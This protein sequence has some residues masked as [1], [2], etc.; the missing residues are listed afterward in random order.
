M[1]RRALIA[2]LTSS[3]VAVVA[4]CSSAA[5]PPSPPPTV[6]PPPVTTPPPLPLVA[7]TAVRLPRPFAIDRAALDLAID[8]AQTTMTGQVRLTGTMA[9]TESVIWLH[10]EDLT[11]TRAVARFA[12]PGPADVAKRAP[13]PIALEVITGLARG[14]IALRAPAPL[15]AGAPYTLELDYQAPID[16]LETAGTFRQQLDGRWYVFS[17]HEAIAARRSFPCIDEPDL[18]IPWTVTLTVPRGLTAVA[19]APE[20]SSTTITDGRQRFGFAPTEAIPS[21]LVAYAVGPFEIVPAG[22]TSGGAPIRIIVPAGK[23]AEAA[24]AAEA[25]PKL[26]AALER[27]FGIPYPFAKLDSLAI[28]TTVGFGAMENPGLITY[29]E[30]LLL[31]PADAPEAR[32]RRYVGVGTHEMAHQW[33]GDLVTP[34]WWDDIW[35]NESFATWMPA[36]VIGAVY[37]AF[38]R[39]EDDALGRGGA[40]G[41]DSL[42]TARR[43]R[44]PIVA[45]D[46]I[47]NAFDGI[48][49]GKGA[50]V[51]RMMEA[52]V[53]ADAFQQGIRAYL[54][55]H[56]RGNAT[57]ADFVAAI[58]A[59]STA[60]DLAAAF[61]SFLDQAGAPQLD[62][63]IDCAAGARP[64]IHLAQR[65]YQT[66][67]A[68]GPPGVVDATRWR[69]PVCVLAGGGGP[70]PERVC[71]VLAGDE[72]RLELARCPRWVWPNADGRGYYRSALSADGWR[73]LATRGWRQLGRADRLA[74]AQ[75]LLAEVGTG[76]V[77]IDVALD[78]VPL[79]LAEKRAPA[80]QL[81]VEPLAGVRPWLAA[82][83]LARLAAWTERR[84]GK[85]ARALGWLPG[86]G[87]T[88]DDEDLRASL[89]PLRARLGDGPLGRAAVTLAADWRSLPEGA[90]R[91]ILQAAV[92]VDPTLGDRLLAD[93]RAEPDHGRAG[94]LAAALGVQF[95]PTRLAASLALVLDASLDLR[96]TLGILTAAVGEPETRA[97]AEQF[98]VDHLDELL[99][100][101]P[102]EWGANLVGALTASCDAARVE[103]MRA[104]AEAKLASHRGARR[105]IDQA[106]ERMNQCIVQRATTIPVVE[107]WLATAK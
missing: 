78:W 71:G 61:S 57:A 58:A 29:S 74:A 85:Q 50:A 7:P 10:A 34:V 46:D 55:A 66:M 37:P 106:F 79:L 20:V 53:G 4:A 42:A 94:D 82:P 23:A 44:Q 54:A 69:L 49:Y 28:P 83:A 97:I 19:N 33:F 35:L 70:K 8:P 41:A 93:L 99:A 3:L 59:H 90:R 32:K 104:L 60:P 12:G 16:G 68:A 62:A 56:A 81:A 65:R 27:W 103:P 84:L 98:A 75:D 89:V 100:R 95:D 18:K 52:W 105:R 76:A 47:V 2:S 73:A 63:T 107:R 91:P 36:K 21:Y 13:A 72:L 26:L 48:S 9:T 30:R 31:M 102:D 92:R 25:T 51:L 6:T 1:S 96:D 86:P 64:A 24:F 15:P 87:D 45:E 39:P 80:V 40:L 22:T 38:R 5:R 43:I 14:R 77:G 17:Q 11:I 67:G 101:M 88:I